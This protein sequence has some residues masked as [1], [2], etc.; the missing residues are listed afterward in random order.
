MQLR[1]L[2]P[3]VLSVVTLLVLFNLS[4]YSIRSDEEAGGANHKPSSPANI[5]TSKD[6]TAT[7]NIQ[8]T[9]GT[10]ATT[11]SPTSAAKQSKQLA[12][13]TFATGKDAETVGKIT[14]PNKAEYAS[15]HGY[16]YYNFAAIK[17]DD[18]PTDTHSIYFTKFKSILATFDMGYE[19][20][21][22]S[23]ADAVFMNF[24]TPLLEFVD[25]AYDVILPVAEPSNEKFHKVPNTGHFMLKNSAWSRK[26]LAY[27]LRIS[28]EPTCKVYPLVNGW[29][30]A[31]LGEG[32]WLGDQGLILWSHQHLERDVSCHTK[33]VSFNDFNSEWP[34]YHEGD[35][36]LHLPG[37]GALNR[38]Q[39]FEALLKVVDLKTGKMDRSLKEFQAIKMDNPEH[40]DSTAIRKALEMQFEKE[41][42]NRACAPGEGDER[43]FEE[44]NLTVAAK[45]GFEPEEQLSN[46]C[47]TALQQRPAAPTTTTTN[48]NHN[49]SNNYLPQ[50]PTTTTTTSMR[51]I[52]L[53]ACTAILTLALC[54]IIAVTADHVERALALKRRNKVAHPPLQQD[55]PYTPA[56]HTP[57]TTTQH[58]QSQNDTIQKH[59]SL[60]VHITVDK[61]QLAIITFAKGASAEQ[62]GKI[63]LPNKQRYAQKHGYGYYNFAT[64]SALP[65]DAQGMYF[66]KFKSILATFDMGYEW[67]LWSDADALFM[68]FSVP[69]LEF[70]DPLYDFILPVGEPANKMYAHV[71]NNGHFMFKNSAWSRAY[72]A[73]ILQ[74]SSQG[75]CEQFGLINGWLQAC[76]RGVFWLDDQGLLVWTQQKFGRDVTCHT[77][78]VSFNHFDS[79]YPWYNEGDLVLHLPGRSLPDRLRI[80]ETLLEILDLDSGKLDRKD[81]R[82]ES[83]RMDNVNHQPAPVVRLEMEAAFE[84]MGWNKPCGANEGNPHVFMSATK[85][86]PTI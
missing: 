28:A 57:P 18:W 39:L 5:K 34:W 56:L 24:S 77:K 17:P 85:T 19:W 26:Y 36:V 50:Q 13:V 40:E 76:D 72:I 78:H 65:V 30:P 29:I 71:P 42:W 2:M 80:F 86:S 8:A 38:I 55:R 3:L 11:A 61:K 48:H 75:H 6:A 9:K 79:E 83:V 49:Y 66:T 1:R 32:F 73:Y 22:W 25:P 68:N 16:G 74:A 4:L 58:P 7:S 27:L 81:P 15:H 10:D 35:L 64:L 59:P 33:F 46:N 20:V 43:V 53:L 44:D 67:V 41:G 84:S 52:L 45:L 23:D 54:N 69:L 62:I 51:N 70:A 12:I 37:R 14:L 21:M 60:P 63:T 82:F 31:C 47:C